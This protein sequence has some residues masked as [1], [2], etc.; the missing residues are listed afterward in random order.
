MEAFETV[1]DANL[2]YYVSSVARGVNLT[3]TPTKT[4]DGQAMVILGWRFANQ[5]NHHHE[6]CEVVALVAKFLWESN[7]FLLYYSHRL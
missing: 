6:T 1:K 3:N 7:L 5:R 4:C 2:A